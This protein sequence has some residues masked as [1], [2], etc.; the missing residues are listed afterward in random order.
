MSEEK[1]ANPNLSGVND[2]NRILCES[3]KSC[4]NFDRGIVIENSKRLTWCASGHFLF[5]NSFVRFFSM[6]RINRMFNTIRISDFAKL[7]YTTHAG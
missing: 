3:D 6:Q 5:L 4:V 7:V 2:Q 1:T